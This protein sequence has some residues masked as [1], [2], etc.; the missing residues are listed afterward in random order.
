MKR[1][2]EQSAKLRDEISSMFEEGTTLQAIAN[3]LEISEPYVRK[4]LQEAGY[5]S[6]RGSVDEEAVVAEYLHFEIPVVGVC[7]K[8]GISTTK[9]YEILARHNVPANARKKVYA[10]RGQRA[11]QLYI[12]GASLND[13][14]DE[15]GVSQPVLHTLLHRQKVPLRR[16]R[17]QRSMYPLPIGGQ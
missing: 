11:I 5:L 12:E 8:H 13:I 10:D 14:Y 9:L 17:R 3:E 16:Q 7:T 6:K 4:L 15:T 2:K 1:T